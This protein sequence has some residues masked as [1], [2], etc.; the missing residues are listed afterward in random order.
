MSEG[1]VMAASAAIVI[2]GAATGVKINPKIARAAS[3]VRM[4]SRRFT[5]KKSPTFGL[6]MEGLLPHDRVRR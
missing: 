2:A 1:I 6:G 5:N 3:K 4:V